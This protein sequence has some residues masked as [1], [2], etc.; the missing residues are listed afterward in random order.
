MALAQRSLPATPQRRKLRQKGQGGRASRALASLRPVRRPLQEAPRARRVPP[1]N[2]A[3]P[4][5]PVQSP[6][7]AEDSE[8]VAGSLNTRAGGASHSRA[9]GDFVAPKLHLSEAAS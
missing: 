5:E 8:R 7:P 2:H 9:D 1:G 4:N 6:R 3:L